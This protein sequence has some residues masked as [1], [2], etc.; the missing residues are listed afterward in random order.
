MNSAFFKAEPVL[1]GDLSKRHPQPETF[2]MVTHAPVELS[3]RA[4]ALC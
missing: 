4:T 2:K 3:G 1:A